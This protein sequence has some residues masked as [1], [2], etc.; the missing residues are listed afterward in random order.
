M[1]LKPMKVIVENAPLPVRHIKPPLTSQPADI[2]T[3]AVIL[4]R[5]NRDL[6]DKRTTNDSLA[7]LSYLSR[8]TA[9]QLTENEAKKAIAHIAAL[10]D[11]K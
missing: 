2:Q 9:R 3:I 5:K 6:Y 8:S 10:K 4:L 11:S 1:K 7:C